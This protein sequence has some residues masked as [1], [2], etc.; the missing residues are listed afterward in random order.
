[1][2]SLALIGAIAALGCENALNGEPTA[3]TYTVAFAAGEGSGTPPTTITAA[4]NASIILPGKG[5]LAEPAAGRAFDG[6][7]DGTAVYSAGDPYLVRGHVTLTARWKAASGGASY[8]VTFNAD[9]GTGSTAKTVASPATTVGTLPADP[10]KTGYVF[11]GWFTERNGGGTQFT[12]TTTVVADLTVYATWDQANPFVGG[13]WMDGNAVRNYK[14]AGLV[15][16]EGVYSEAEVFNANTTFNIQGT[17]TY[18]IERKQL[19]LRPEGGSP[20]NIPFELKNS[21]LIFNKGLAG[22]MWLTKNPETGGGFNGEP[23]PAPLGG[24]WQ[25]TTNPNTCLGFNKDGECFLSDMQQRNRDGK[26][27]WNVVA[28]Y[29]YDAARNELALYYNDGIDPYVGTSN[30]YQVEFTLQNQV[31]KLTELNEGITLTLNKR[32]NI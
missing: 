7:S 32:D 4:E 8:T 13:I 10:A 23:A 5:A 14:F 12:A 20:R 31:M 3:A 2:F 17:Y 19:T 25:D 15:N 1:M 27:W 30:I 6:W 18:N 24:M 22:E 26:F 11:G 28:S 16:G 29:E 9:G 21:L